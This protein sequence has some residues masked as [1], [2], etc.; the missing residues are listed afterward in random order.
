MNRD[1]EERVQCGEGGVTE[2][3]TMYTGPPTDPTTMP[4]TA[5]PSESD[6]TVSTELPTPSGNPTNPP[7]ISLGPMA[8]EETTTFVATTLESRR[9]RRNLETFQSTH[10]CFA[11]RVDFSK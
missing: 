3:T 7:E 8:Q 10:R 9:H 4:V 6:T 2:T 11:I 5:P 1:A